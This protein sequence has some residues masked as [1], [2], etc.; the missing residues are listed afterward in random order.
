[1]S[2]YDDDLIWTP[3]EREQVLGFRPQNENPLNALLPYAS[4]LDEESKRLFDEIKTNL[5]KAILLRELKP[6]ACV[7]TS[8]LLKYEFYYIV[9]VLG[10]PKVCKSSDCIEKS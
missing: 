5:G 7:W 6:G 10:H 8:R 3:E 9:F 4:E 1:M 2:Y